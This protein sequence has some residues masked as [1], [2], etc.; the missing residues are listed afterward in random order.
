MSQWWCWCSY[1]RTEVMSGNARGRRRVVKLSDSVGGRRDVL[2][3]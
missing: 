3:F 2:K 1:G